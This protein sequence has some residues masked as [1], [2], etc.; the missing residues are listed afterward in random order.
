M[1]PQACQTLTGNAYQLILEAEK[2]AWWHQQLRTTGCR[3]HRKHSLL[4]AL[5]PVPCTR[6]SVQLWLR[7]EWLTSRGHA[8]ELLSACQQVTSYDNQMRAG[9]MSA[10]RNSI[11]GFGASF[12]GLSFTSS[13]A[14]PRAPPCVPCLCLQAAE[15]AAPPRVRAC[16]TEVMQS[17]ARISC[18]SYVADSSFRA[19][20]LLRTHWFLPVGQHCGWWGLLFLSGHWRAIPVLL[21]PGGTH[22][23]ERG[24]L[25]DNCWYH[26][27][28]FSSGC[29]N[30]QSINSIN[31]YLGCL[32]AS[33]RTNSLQFLRHLTPGSGL[34]PADIT[35]AKSLIDLTYYPR[36][37]EMLSVF[38]HEFATAWP[39]V[40]DP[41]SQRP[42]TDDLAGLPIS[43][44]YLH[45]CQ[46]FKGPWVFPR[47]RIQDDV[48]HEVFKQPY[49][50]WEAKLLNNPL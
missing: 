50:E 45:V 27:I 5:A 28:L 33:A 30:W 13:W 43:S 40:W 36:D 9:F 6:L 48:G 34:S 4:T 12:Q 15:R 29:R 16:H 26:R 14:H 23:Q 39:A 25:T 42:E 47:S 41:L 21:W 24:L 2:R 46:S 19:A 20:P 35:R 11:L 1:L 10:L 38:L 37:G 7:K 44:V 8:R 18:L 17:P 3:F 31:K 22:R 32:R 49:L